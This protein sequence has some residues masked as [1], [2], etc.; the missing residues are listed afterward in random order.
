MNMKQVSQ[1]N[2]KSPLKIWWCLVSVEKSEMQCMHINGHLKWGWIFS[3]MSISQFLC[4]IQ[5]E[6]CSTKHSRTVPKLQ[7]M[8]DAKPW[9][10]SNVSLLTS[11]HKA[12]MSFG[13]VVQVIAFLVMYLFSKVCIWF[14]LLSEFF[15]GRIWQEEKIHTKFMNCSSYWFISLHLFSNHN[16][17]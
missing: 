9:A 12:G 2:Y 6:F 3:Q 4:W 11:H 5:R 16:L 15:I 13:F 14:H 8:K 17:H 1:V 7:V 10:F